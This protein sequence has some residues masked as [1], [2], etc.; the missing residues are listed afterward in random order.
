METVASIFAAVTNLTVGCARTRFGKR[1]EQ[2]A[3]IL[4][5]DVE[6]RSVPYI[7]VAERNGE[8]DEFVF[9]GITPSMIQKA[10]MEGVEI[11]KTLPVQQNPILRYVR[12]G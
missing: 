8:T 11:P 12:I 6:R 2:V 5:Y 3:E 10:K 1:V 7:V 4:P 9:H